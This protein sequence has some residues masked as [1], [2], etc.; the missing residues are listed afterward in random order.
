VGNLTASGAGLQAS[1]SDLRAFFAEVLQSA[2]DD[3]PELGLAFFETKSKK[4][5]KVP[6]DERALDE[7]VRLG[8]ELRTF[9]TTLAAFELDAPRRAEK[10]KLAGGFFFDADLRGD[11]HERGFESARRFEDFLAELDR[12]GFA[13]SLLV[14]TGGGWHLSYLFDEW[15]ELDG[16]AGRKLRALGS[17][18]QATLA[19]LAKAYDGHLD[20]WRGFHEYTRPAGAVRQKED[21]A[22]NLV[23][24]HRKPGRKVRRYS[25]SEIEERLELE[26]RAYLKVPKALAPPS[27]FSAH[28]VPLRWAKLGDAVLEALG[29]AGE[30]RFVEAEPSAFWRFGLCPA[31]NGGRKK[32]RDQARLLPSGRLECARAS[33]PAYDRRGT[34][35]GLGGLR[36]EE[37]LPLAGIVGTDK[38]NLERLRRDEWHEARDKQ[39]ASAGGREL[40]PADARR[41]DRS[42]QDASSAWEA[43]LAEELRQVSADA[44]LEARSRGA[45]LVTPAGSGKSTVL[46]EIIA[47]ER[48]SAW[49]VALRDHNLAREWEAGLRELGVEVQRLEGI[50]SACEWKED[51]LALGSPWE[52]WKKT[53]C[54][55]CEFRDACKAHEK[56]KAGVAALVTTHERLLSST[57]E[58]RA[59]LVGERRVLV[60][61]RPEPLGFDS[62]SSAELARA[63]V[64][65]MRPEFQAVLAPVVEALGKLHEKARAGFLARGGTL[66]EHGARIPS[67]ELRAAFAAVLGPEDSSLRA[68]FAAV[69]SYRS[70]DV[71]EFDAARAAVYSPR[72]SPAFAQYL[73]TPRTVSRLWAWLHEAQGA[74]TTAELFLDPDGAAWALELRTRRTLPASSLVLD[75]T[76]YATRHELAPVFGGAEPR[77]FALDA[78]RAPEHL[79]AWFQTGEAKRSNLGAGGSLSIGGRARLAEVFERT[80]ARVE[81]GKTLAKIE[82]RKVRVG[83]LTFKTAA[84]TLRRELAGD[85]DETLRALNLDPDRFDLTPETVGHYGRDESGTNRFNGCDLFVLFGDPVP[86]VGA[87]EADA[88]ALGLDAR[89][90]LAGRRDAAVAQGIARPR[91]LRSRKD[92]LGVVVAAFT[93][94]PP[95]GWR[96]GDFLADLL[97]PGR[98]ATELGRAVAELR[99]VFEQSGELRLDGQALEDA[100]A[101][102]RQ[103]A[104]KRESEIAPH[105][106]SDGLPRMGRQPS[107]STLERAAKALLGE[108]LESGEAVLEERPRPGGRRPERILRRAAAA[109]AETSGHI[110][111]DQFAEARK[112]L[113]H[114][115]TDRFE[116]AARAET[117]GHILTDRELEAVEPVFEAVEPSG[118][119]LTWAS[120]AEFTWEDLES[121]TWGDLEQ[122]DEALVHAVASTP[123][124]EARLRALAVLRRAA[125]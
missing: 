21:R 20:P 99:A 114:I 79:R 27:K 86:N 55:G 5:R 47:G 61:E 3:R 65:Y 75:A 102:I 68:A 10:A 36:L 81:V 125:S 14:R 52:W 119:R 51:F 111:T 121:L 115:L 98:K 100:A 53:R 54:Q 73:A 69:A 15:Q 107:R 67:D 110:L 46:R 25:P 58:A 1:T 57:G 89:E 82:G 91:D 88:R 16:A 101:A 96:A 44:L 71:F 77:L 93:S 74:P 122:L 12:R 31:C 105:V 94:E 41:L 112:A 43:R 124:G 49:L 70:E 104:H 30:G 117:K 39:A 33:C 113:G 6:L 78:Q 29:A 9:G 50:A 85:R 66:G 18:L 34:G 84:E 13:P 24:W 48:S 72:I 40:F 28:A 64:V 118:R 7:A 97:T 42:A 37:W 38:A 17:T 8:R 106:H 109:K 120:A 103:N 90:L 59:E 32:S 4:L 60:D 19:E 22:P 63:G 56:P 92:G 87:M 76:A 45:V 123:P 35:E 23:R 116:P 11:A 83:L 2:P 108:L 62:L 26:L 80:L 95:P